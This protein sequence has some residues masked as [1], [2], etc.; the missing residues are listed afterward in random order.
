MSSQISH[1]FQKRTK[2][3]YEQ[4]VC[5]FNIMYLWYICRNEKITHTHTHVSSQ[6]NV[7]YPTNINESRHY[8]SPF[9]SSSDVGTHNILWDGFNVC[10]HNHQ[11]HTCSWVLISKRVWAPCRPF[12]ATIDLSTRKSNPPHNTRVRVVNYFSEKKKRVIICPLWEKELLTECSVSN[13]L[14]PFSCISL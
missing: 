1:L 12:L 2:S 11:P 7:L 6:Y 3:L 4:N 10:G 8:V 5:T 13:C 9:T 14:Y